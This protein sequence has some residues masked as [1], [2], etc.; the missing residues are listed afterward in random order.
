MNHRQARLTLSIVVLAAIG[1]FFQN[2][3]RSESIAR[4]SGPPVHR[5]R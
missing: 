4:E 3:M 2:C 1:I 5:E